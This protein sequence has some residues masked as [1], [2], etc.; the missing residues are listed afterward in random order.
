MS[1]ST[2]FSP[3]Y[4]H[5]QGDLA[6]V[7]LPDE[8]GNKVEVHLRSQ[9]KGEAVFR[10]RQRQSQQVSKEEVLCYLTISQ[11]DYNGHLGARISSIFVNLFV[12]S[13]VTVVPVLAKR[14]S[15]WKIPQNVYLFARYFGTGVIV[16]TAFVHLLDPAYKRSGPKACV[17]ESGYWGKYSWCAGIVLTTVCLSSFFWILPQ[18]V[19][20]EHKYDVHKD[21]EA[22]NAFIGHYSN[23]FYYSR[24]S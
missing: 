20:V 21:E 1:T 3:M 16:A 24:Y 14:M 19:Y 2:G 17:G 15:S 11:N 4:T 9:A 13:A 12:S 7:W 8:L 6:D 23:Y 5:I 18:K 22:T 10:S